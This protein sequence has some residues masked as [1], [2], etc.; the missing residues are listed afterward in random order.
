MWEWPL[1]EVGKW[2]PAAPR[3]PQPGEQR[4]QVWGEGAADLLTMEAETVLGPG[5][6]ESGAAWKAN[7]CHISEE[8]LP[9]D[10]G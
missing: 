2:P 5:N 7:T 10:A 4:T 1:V 9:K 8:Q 6:E 3:S